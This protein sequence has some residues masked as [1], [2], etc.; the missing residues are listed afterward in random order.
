[1]KENAFLEANGGRP[2]VNNILILMNDGIADEKE[3]AEV[4]MY[5]VYN[6]AAWGGCLHS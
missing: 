2:G 1:M 3:Q 4:S 6:L 5:Y